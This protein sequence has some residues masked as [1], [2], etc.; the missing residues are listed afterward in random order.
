MTGRASL[1]LLFLLAGPVAAEGAPSQNA[2]SWSA[3]VVVAPALADRVARLPVVTLDGRGNTSAIWEV[4][5]RGGSGYVGAT[6]DWHAGR[7]WTAPTQLAGGVAAQLAGDPQGDLLAVWTD[8]EGISQRIRA[9]F[10][11]RGGR[12]R[13][14]VFVS[15]AGE[16]ASVPKAALDARGRA[17]VVWT[18]YSS[19]S[20][21][22]ESASRGT[23]GRWS[24]AVTLARG[25]SGDPDIAMNASGRALVV[26]NGQTGMTRVA[27]RSPTGNWTAPTTLSSPNDQGHNP[28]VALNAAGIAIAVWMG[29][30]SGQ[31]AQTL[32]AAIRPAGRRFG[33]PRVVLGDI[34]GM[35]KVALAAN[36]EAVVISSDRDLLYSNVRPPGGR[37][38]S[39]QILGNGFAPTVGV[40]ARG[41]AIA[42]WTRSDG[43]NLFVHAARRPSRQGFDSSVE[44]AEYP[45][46]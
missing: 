35:S 26:W 22:V 19:A 13:A 30:P 20:F 33:P 45:Q 10:R 25:I 37:F 34:T 1:L 4:F 36:G 18:G 7:G 44:A 23:T 43:T 21:T 28:R 27:S 15:P 40:D 12:W 31:A 6:A 8:V 38:G 17:L 42:V 24:Q 41:D 9:A 5:S 11:P 16:Q 29:A 14:P 2:G 3:P 39:R 32:E 46:S